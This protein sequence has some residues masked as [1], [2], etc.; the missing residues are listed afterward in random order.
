[1]QVR[2]IT[3]RVGEGFSQAPGE[4]IDL[5]AAEAARLIEAH[6]AEPVETA[7][8][9]TAMRAHPRGRKRKKGSDS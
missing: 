6:A 2:L 1:M 3:S 7:K 5:P 9:E 8:K 4:V